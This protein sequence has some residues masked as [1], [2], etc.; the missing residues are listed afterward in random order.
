MVISWQSCSRSLWA[1]TG[2]PG[3][4]HAWAQDADSFS[5]QRIGMVCGLEPAPFSGEQ[6]HKFIPV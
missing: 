2:P 1:A 4:D 5:P 3:V 6:P